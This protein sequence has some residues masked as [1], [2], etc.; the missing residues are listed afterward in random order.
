M[1]VIRNVEIL[2]VFRFGGT[3]SSFFL[4]L[5]GVGAQFENQKRV[6]SLASSLNISFAFAAISRI[7]FN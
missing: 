5:D 7:E 3:N 1:C 4:P 2:Y 6:G